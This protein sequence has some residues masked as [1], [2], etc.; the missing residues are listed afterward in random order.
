M[1]GGGGGRVADG[2]VFGLFGRTVI[3]G[4]VHHTDS[5][6][7]YYYG[8]ETFFYTNTYVISRDHRWFIEG[9]GVRGCLAVTANT[10][11]KSSPLFVFALTIISSNHHPSG[12]FENPPQSGFYLFP[13]PLA[14]EPYA[15]A[16]PS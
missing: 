4:P 14:L 6:R 9:T 3:P 1:T 7:N 13:V 16:W 11:T 10:P 15:I 2:H 12:A 8:I 5:N